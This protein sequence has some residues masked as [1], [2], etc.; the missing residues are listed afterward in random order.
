M[1][2]G[3]GTK[4][5]GQ[6]AQATSGGDDVAVAG[7][8]VIHSTDVFPQGVKCQFVRLLTLYY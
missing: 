3:V 1:M 8:V 4:N 7:G 5:L 6:N 2:H